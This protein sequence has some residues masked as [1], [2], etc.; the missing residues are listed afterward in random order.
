MARVTDATLWKTVKVTIEERGTGAV[1][2]PLKRPDGTFAVTTQEKIG[3]L[4]PVLMPVVEESVE[5]NQSEV[6]SPPLVHHCPATL[7]SRFLQHLRRGHEPGNYY[8]LQ[9]HRRRRR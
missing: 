9:Q 8:D 7:P 2:C 5:E 3:I 4:L 6:C 1:S